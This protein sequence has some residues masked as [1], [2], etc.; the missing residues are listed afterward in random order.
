MTA[1]VVYSMNVS[2]DGFINDRNGSLEWADVDEEVHGWFN[3][4][5]RDAAAFVYGR[6]MYETMAAYWPF[7]LDEPDASPVIVDFA[8][9]WQRK[10][11]RVFSRSLRAVDSNVRLTA[12]DIVDALPA[13]K[14]DFDGEL[15]VGGASLAASLIERNLVDEY[16]LVMH[17]VLLGGGTPF[18]PT[19][20]SEVRLRPTETRGFANGA[21]LLSYAAR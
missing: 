5:A 19:C 20:A 9:I 11:K 2:L 15:D 16:R 12:D 1:R 21:V 18:F 7:A 8:Q 3:D 4:R 10:P 17:P 13:L 14:R 6:R